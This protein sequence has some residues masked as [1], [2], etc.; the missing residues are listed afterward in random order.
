[1]EKILVT[2]FTWA[3]NPGVN[4]F[5]SKVVK[6]KGMIFNNLFKKNKKASLYKKNR[7]L[8]L[9]VNE[10]IEETS[11]AKTVVFEQE[12][13]YEPGQYLT[14]IVEKDGVE[15]RRSYSLCSSPYWQDKPAITIKKDKA[16]EISPF[17]FSSLKVGNEVSAMLP[18][19]SFT[20]ICV[21]DNKRKV[22]MIG[23]GSGITPL[24]SIMKSILREEPQ[25]EVNLIYANRNQDSVI[26]RSQLEQLKASYPN[27]FRM[28]E[29]LSQPAPGWNGHQGR[30][31]QEK[32]TTIFEEMGLM[33]QIKAKE[34]FI[35]GP[36]GMMD[37]TINFLSSQD[38]PADRVH[39]ESFISTPREKPEPENKPEKEGEKI[40]KVKV[41]L[42][43]EEH[44]FDVEPD[45]SILETALDLNIDMPF[46]C[47]SG[48]CTACR[49]KKISGEIMMEEDEGLS[50]REKDEGYVLV[51]VG[52]PLTD[53]VVL[54]VE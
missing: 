9:T 1:M 31:G 5:L 8:Q 27:N 32:I 51:C 35:C 48:I 53:D 21:A 12:F 3:N 42:D 11:E 50:Q 2:N 13:D 6:V 47:Q 38:I 4:P 52:H 23:A 10:I 39:K 26:F 24:M 34:F 33:D 18:L 17:L 28:T 15:H 37:A 22:V 46:S 54:K 14:L 19:G 36:Q 16:G 40:R 41:L 49:C 25:S 20:T 30:L 45:K 7:Y 43:G 44:E 29:I